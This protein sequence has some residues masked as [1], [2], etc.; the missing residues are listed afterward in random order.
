MVVFIDDILIYSRPKEKHAEHLRIV[1]ITLEEHKLYAKL[2]KCEFWLDKVHF[3]GLVVINDRISI[4]LIK[5]KAKVNWSKPTT[6]TEVVSFLGMTRY[7]RRFIEGFSNL[8]FNITRLIH[9]NFKFEWS[10][11]CEHSFQEI[12]KRLVSALIFAK[13]KDL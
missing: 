9:N 1:L 10:E 4:D 3:L 2:K 8:V 7:Y 6:M 11:E 5:V 13:L 12:K